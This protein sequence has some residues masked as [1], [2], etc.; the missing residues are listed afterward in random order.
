MGSRNAY[1]EHAELAGHVE[2]VGRLIDGYQSSYGMEL[3][4]SVHWVAVH[5]LGVHSLADAVA[6]VHGWNDRKKTLMTPQHIASAWYRL[7]QEGWLTSIA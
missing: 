3:L 6:A 2:R 7:E 1:Q 4:A 5:E